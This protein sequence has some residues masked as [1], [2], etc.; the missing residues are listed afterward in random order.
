V[1]H[2]LA[3]KS[4]ELGENSAVSPDEECEKLMTLHGQVYKVFSDDEVRAGI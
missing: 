1:Q 3:R 4:V 2:L